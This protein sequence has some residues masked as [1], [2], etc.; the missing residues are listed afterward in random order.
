MSAYNL[1]N[2]NLVVSIW[3]WQATV[4]PTGSPAVTTT[5]NLTPGRRFFLAINAE[6]PTTSTP[7]GDYQTSQNLLLPKGTDVRVGWMLGAMNT[8]SDIILLPTYPGS[9]WYAVSMCDVARGFPNE[10]R[11]IGLF[12]I[13]PWVV[14]VP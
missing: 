3:R 14:P 13:A 8:H 2:F 12:P 11:M 1:P 5:G 10:Y 6:Q 7:F 4:P 9:Y